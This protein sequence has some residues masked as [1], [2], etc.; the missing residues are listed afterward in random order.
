MKQMEGICNTRNMRLHT[1]INKYDH[2]K[3]TNFLQSIFT[4]KKNKTKHKKNWIFASLNRWNQYGT[5]SLALE[6]ART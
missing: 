4:I 1:E 3:N 6:L 2:F 5:T